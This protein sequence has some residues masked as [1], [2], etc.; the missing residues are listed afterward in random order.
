MRRLSSHLLGVDQGSIVLFSDYQDGGAMWTG[1]GPRELRRLVQFKEPFLTLPVVQV[2]L[3]MWDMDQK[4]NQRADISA[5]AVSL[6][7]FAI[8]FRTW[9]D[10]RVARV[11]SDWL[12]IGEVKGEDDW[13]IS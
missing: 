12:A 2:T 11:R 4:T 3:S 10:T 8:V 1:D 6:E 5:E 7:G 9:G 13:D